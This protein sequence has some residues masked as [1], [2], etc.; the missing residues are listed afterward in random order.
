MTSLGSGMARRFRQYRTFLGECWFYLGAE[1]KTFVA[2]VVLSVLGALTEGIGISLFVPLLDALAQQSAFAS[3]P[4]LSRIGDLFSGIPYDTRIRIVAVLML[5]VVIARSAFHY[6]VQYLNIYLPAKIER[7]L[8]VESYSLMLRMDLALTNRS[9][10]GSVLNFVS[11]YPSRIGQVMGYLGNLISNLALLGIY[12]GMMLLISVPLTLLSLAFTGFVF[13][14]QRAISSGPLR[15]A[16]ADVTSSGENLGQI[17]YETLAGLSLIRLSVA[18]GQM[19]AR[20]EQTTALLRSAQNRY[21]SASALIV[22]MFVLSSGVLICVFLFIAAGYG[23]SVAIALLFLFLLQRLLAPVSAVTFARNSILLHMDAMN[24]FKE[25]LGRATRNVQKDGHVPFEGMK[26]GI[27]FRA[28]SFSYDDESGE[29][30]KEISFGIPKGAMTAIVGPSGAGKSTVVSLLGR[31]Y[32]PQGGAVEVDGVDL[33]DYKMD[34]WRRTISVVSQSVFLLNDTIE[35]NL[36]FGLNRPVSESEIRAAADLAACSEFIDQMPDGYRTMLGERGTRL[37]GGQQQRL[38]I[39]RAILVD[40]QLLILD[41]ATSHLDSI[42]EHA[43]Q[44]AMSTFGRTRTLVVIAHRLATIKR[45]DNIIVMDS[46]RV[47][48]QGRHDELIRNRGRYWE[49]I[50]YQRL[51]LVEDEAV[52][53]V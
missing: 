42:T 28:V 45:A 3:V 48:E 26:H 49:M 24:E 40:P 13:Y 39:A 43:I 2:F 10:A 7:R 1:K 11:G 22:P 37:S 47:V 25:W 5:V 51:D 50:E 53:G 21:A 46:G 52:A 8:R 44:R 14:L 31:L 27:R 36:T 35:R 16:G 23:T 30:L 12:T 34:T 41:E 15:Q 6:I 4:F 20:H 17:I 9:K 29:V 19:E 33:R 32:D 38:A 18:T